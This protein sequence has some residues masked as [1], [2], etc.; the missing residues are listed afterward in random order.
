MGCKT[1]TTCFD[2]NWSYTHSNNMVVDFME[3]LWNCLQHPYNHLRW[4]SSYLGQT[5]QS[6]RSVQRSTKS[7]SR[8]LIAITL[9]PLV[10]WPWNF[11]TS[12][13][14]KLSTI[15][16]LTSFTEKVTIILNLSTQQKLLMQPFSWIINAIIN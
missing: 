5:I 9:K 11:R 12:N 14:S 2:H 13:M 3:I 6:F 16:L 15:L 1:T 4:L 8:L 10:L 7:D